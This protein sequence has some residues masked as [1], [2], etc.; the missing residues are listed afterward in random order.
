MNQNVCTKADRNVRGSSAAL[1]VDILVTKF[2]TNHSFK[3][4]DEFCPRFT[5]DHFGEMN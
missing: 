2:E 4:T 5:A 1:L 3:A